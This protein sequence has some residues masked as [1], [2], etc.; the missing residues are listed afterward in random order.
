MSKRKLKI[1][2]L[3]CPNLSSVALLNKSRFVILNSNLDV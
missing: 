2:P 3:I 1:F